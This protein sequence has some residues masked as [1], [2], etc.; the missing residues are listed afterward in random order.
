MTADHVSEWLNR[1]TDRNV[2]KPDS[3]LVSFV[4]EKELTLDMQV[5]NGVFSE[6]ATLQ[7]SCS[8]HF[9]SLSST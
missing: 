3:G 8:R 2:Y 1:V 5:K 4:S 9:S 7:Y 6:G